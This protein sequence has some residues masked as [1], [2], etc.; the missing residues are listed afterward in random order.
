MINGEGVVFF[1]STAAL[2]RDAPATVPVLVQ[3]AAAAIAHQPVAAKP[4]KG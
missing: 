1:S 2:S 4:V 3:A